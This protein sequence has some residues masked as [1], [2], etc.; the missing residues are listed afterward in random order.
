[1]QD[2]D[3]PDV[4]HGQLKSYRWRRMFWSSDML[5]T[6]G[7]LYP[8]TSAT[9]MEDGVPPVLG[10]SNICGQLPSKFP[11]FLYMVISPLAYAATISTRIS[12][13]TSAA[14]TD[15]WLEVSPDTTCSDQPSFAL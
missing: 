10:D 2:G 3:V 15:I 6:S 12:M 5:M 7:K 8:S 13:S 14:N 11:S 4:P 1:M 9:R